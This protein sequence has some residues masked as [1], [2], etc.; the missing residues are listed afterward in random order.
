MFKCI[1]H[2]IK[3]FKKGKSRTCTWVQDI[4]GIVMTDNVNLM[5]TIGPN[6]ALP[7]PNNCVFL[8]DMDNFVRLRAH[9]N[10]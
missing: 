7:F 9:T 3:P 2:A 6:E 5:P 10:L 1:G 8:G 4:Y